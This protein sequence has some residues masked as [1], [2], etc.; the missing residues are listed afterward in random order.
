M[1]KKL[2]LALTV[3]AL[4][5]NVTGCAN[6]DTNISNDIQNTVTE[7]NKENTEC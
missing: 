2:I 3:C 6:K 5:L 4:C 1:K 7:N